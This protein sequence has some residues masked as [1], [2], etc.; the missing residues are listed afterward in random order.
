MA[1]SEDEVARLHKANRPG[2]QVHLRAETTKLIIY[3]YVE[4]E[5]QFVCGRMYK[6]YSKVDNVKDDWKVK[7]GLNVI[8]L[9]RYAEWEEWPTIYRR[10]SL[11]IKVP[12]QFIFLGHAPDLDRRWQIVIVT[13]NLLFSLQDML[14][15]RLGIQFMRQEDAVAHA[16]EQ[17]GVDRMLTTNRELL[18]SW[19]LSASQKVL[20]RWN[21]SLT[22]NRSC[23]LLTKETNG[24]DG[25]SMGSD[26]KFFRAFDVE[27]TMRYAWGKKWFEN[28]WRAIMDDP[29][30]KSRDT[31][32]PFFD[33]HD[34]CVGSYSYYE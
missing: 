31:F 20:L 21:S 12:G 1:I 17:D 2:A 11:N 26:V 10:I 8:C 19:K 27:F 33:L 14:A 30:W 34:R 13:E 16:R 28:R 23:P 24:H 25:V 9:C 6:N 15:M 32:V 5:L 18:D 7:P 29:Y 4:C 22:R 3:S